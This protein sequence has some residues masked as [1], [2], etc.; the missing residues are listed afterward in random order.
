MRFPVRLV[1]DGA[2]LTGGEL[3]ATQ[4]ISDAPADG[5]VMHIAPAFRDRMDVLPMIVAYQLVAV[6]YGDVA[7]HEEA[8][9]FG[10]TLLGMEQEGYYQV[11]CGLADG[12]KG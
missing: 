1:F 5:F 12:L 2:E 9:V 3:A 10:S 7:T 4:Q 8:E 6:N 11:L